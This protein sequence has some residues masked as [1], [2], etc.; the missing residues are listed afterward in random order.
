MESLSSQEESANDRLHIVENVDLNFN[1]EVCILPNSAQFTQ[2]NIT[3]ELKRLG[4]NISQKKY[5]TLM[6]TLDNFMKLLP[7][8]SKADVD[9]NASL[10][11]KTHS[12]N[13]ESF[14]DAQE[15]PSDISIVDNTSVQSSP[16]KAKRVQ[17]SDDEVPSLSFKFLVSNLNVLLENSK[18]GGD[19]AS[20][21]IN[22]FSLAF[23]QKSYQSSVQLN[24]GDIVIEDRTESNKGQ[25]LLSTELSDSAEEGSKLISFKLIMIP[26]DSP[27]FDE[28]TQNITMSLTNIEL[29]ILRDSILGLHDFIITTLDDTKDPSYNTAVESSEGSISQSI[30]PNTTTSYPLS[31][32]IKCTMESTTIRLDRSPNDRLASLKFENG[33]LQ[34][35]YSEEK[36][37]VLGKLKDVS[38]ENE[39]MNDTDDLYI[40]SNQGD[41]T[42]DMSLDI[43]LV[44]PIN[45]IY[46]SSLKLTTG[47]VHFN[48]IDNKIINII[49]YLQEFS[50]MHATLESAR[51]AATVSANLIQNQTG[52]FKFDINFSNPVL[53]FGRGFGVV[54]GIE[55][56]KIYLGQISLSNDMSKDASE[57]IINILKMNV[58][59]LC[60]D[61]AHKVIQDADC[62]LQIVMATN[63][64]SEEL[65]DR[66]TSKINV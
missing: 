4:L 22:N 16:K 49:Q 15:H 29:I 26:R 14:Y 51:N 58:L 47:S 24:V 35:I 9:D 25:R 33:T 53:E 40:I 31:M 10:N 43:I 48:I 2:T 56:F 30:P 44:D 32:M 50:D 28:Y 54:C 3:G 1:L 17:V 5:K 21:T 46:D 34:V 13:E 18:S 63:A 12:D 8:G 55:R 64:S 20:L 36:I 60:N 7:G 45:R 6:K 42:I 11:S 37:Q 23:E 57:I 52:A 66:S 38:L 39:K 65:S 27:R 59:S 19:V 61:V 62:R 41:H